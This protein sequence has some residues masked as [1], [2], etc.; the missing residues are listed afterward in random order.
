MGWFARMLQGAAL[1]VF[2]AIPPFCDRYHIA[3]ARKPLF[4]DHPMGG[5]YVLGKRQPTERFGGLS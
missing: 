1:T 2:G 4:I 5:R 3:L